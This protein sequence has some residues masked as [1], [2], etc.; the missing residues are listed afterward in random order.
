MPFPPGKITDLRILKVDL[1][2]SLVT[3]QFTAQG[4]FMSTGR[5]EYFYN[6]DVRTFVYYH[7]LCAGP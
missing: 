1:K 7:I 5:G 3:V 2:K 4:A 6:M